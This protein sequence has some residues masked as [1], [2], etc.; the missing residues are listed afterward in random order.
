MR[1]TRPD[2]DLPGMFVPDESRGSRLPWEQDR[3]SG[4]PRPGGMLGRDVGR[5]LRSLPSSLQAARDVLADLAGVRDRELR[6]ADWG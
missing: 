2:A 6:D 3:A 1:T 5:L 4:F